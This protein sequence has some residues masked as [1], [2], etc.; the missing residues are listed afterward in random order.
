ML[1]LFVVVVV[2]VVGGRRCAVVKQE[3]APALVNWPS[4]SAR[5]LRKP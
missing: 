5:P 3:P 4:A 2:G 1:V